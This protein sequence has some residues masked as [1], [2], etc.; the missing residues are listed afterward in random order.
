MKKFFIIFFKILDYV[1]KKEYEINSYLSG[2]RFNVTNFLFSYGKTIKNLYK[3]Y[4]NKK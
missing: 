4:E 3:M 1:L 2:V